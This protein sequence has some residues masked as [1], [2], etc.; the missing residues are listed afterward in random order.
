[1]RHNHIITLGLAALLA[2]VS[3]Q[4]EDVQSTVVEL[5]PQLRLVQ[6]QSQTVEIP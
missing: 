5:T 6:V 2:V 1:M 3:C 4:Q